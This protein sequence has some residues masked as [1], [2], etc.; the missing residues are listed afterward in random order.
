MRGMLRWPSVLL[1]IGGLFVT[2]GCGDDDTTPMPGTD[3]GP[4]GDGGMMTTDAGRDAGPNPPDGG[5]PGD[6]GT[7]PNVAP[8]AARLL[9]D[10][11]DMFTSPTDA[12]PTNDGV[13]VFFA[14]VNTA[15]EATLFSVPSAGGAV[16]VVHAGAPFVYPSGLAMSCDG[17]K[18][19]VADAAA[20]ADG[21]GRLFSVNTTGSGTPT[22]IAT[23]ALLS[24][25]SITVDRDCNNLIV[26]GRSA[27]A[28]PGLFR[29]AVAGGAATAIDTGASLVSPSGVAVASN[30]DLYVV[31]HMAQGTT[32]RGVLFKVTSAGA[33]TAL[34]SGLVLGYPAGV[35]LTAG[36]GLALV[37]TRA[38][39]SS[40]V[41]TT[42][43][44]PAGTVGATADLVTGSGATDFIDPAGLHGS[45]ASGVFAIADS[46]GNAIFAAE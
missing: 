11:T 25:N 6:A 13:T 7:L 23:T 1:L 10:S 18:V 29:V 24:P 20:G 16:T 26:S 46:E 2:A 8:T 33:P 22:E 5:P 44:V 39:G 30:G 3:A 37:S 19:F 36:G 31:D 17:T 45:R 4:G 35:T 15:G 32:G 21:E 9:A 28:V 38:G 41:L 40:S 12:V 43:A 14:A 34:A 42:I 27:A